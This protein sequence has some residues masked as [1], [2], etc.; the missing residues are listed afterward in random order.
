MKLTNEEQNWLL[1]A[2][3]KQEFFS[4]CTVSEIKEIISLVTKKHYDGKEI[5][6][7]QGGIG[8]FFFIIGKGT[9]SVILEKEKGKEEKLSELGPGD[10]FGEIALITGHER[11]A[12]VLTKESC[13]LFLLY[14]N[15]FLGLLS[16]NSGLEIKVLRIVEKRLNER[17]IHLSEPQ[18]KS[19]LDRLKQLI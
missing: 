13:E 11:N 15:D 16:K 18:K 6:I 5:V 3:K 17:K 14:R 1:E 4:V 10:F 9:V 7:Q 8:D 2:L 19:I 12:T